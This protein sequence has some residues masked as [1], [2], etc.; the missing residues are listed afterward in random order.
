MLASAKLGIERLWNNLWGYETEYQ[1]IENIN[2]K[3]LK[4]LFFIL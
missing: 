4:L 1:I 2:L 3:Q